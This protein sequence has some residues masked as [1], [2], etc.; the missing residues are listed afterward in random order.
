MQLVLPLS[1]ARRPEAKAP[2]EQAAAPQPGNLLVY[3]LDFTLIGP[4]TLLQA[5]VLTGTNF[6]VSGTLAASLDAPGAIYLLNIAM[7]SGGTYVDVGNLTYSY[8]NDVLTVT[9]GSSGILQP[10]LY[11]LYLAPQ[12]SVTLPIHIPPGSLPSSQ[13]SGDP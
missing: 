6:D 3:G 2:G 5:L 13:P 10:G 9:G 1:S 7:V 11:V 12:S 8:A 4:S